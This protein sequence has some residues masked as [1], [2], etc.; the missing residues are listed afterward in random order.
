M[1]E[2]ERAP[3]PRRRR[4]PRGRVA[5]PSQHVR[6]PGGTG[7][8]LAAILERP[9]GGTP[10]SCA[11]LAHAFASSKDLR[12]YSRIADALV[13]KGYALLRFD[14]TGLGQSG[15]E[16]RDTTFSTEIDDLVAAADFMRKE[17]EAPS[18]LIGHSLGGACVLAGAQRIPES[19]AVAT[20]A[21]P[22][23][24][25]HLRRKLLRMAP[26]LETEEYANAD[27]IGKTITLS[28]AMLDDLAGH[29]LAAHV[30]DLDRA[31]LV[32]HS[33]LDTFV[34]IEHAARIFQAAKHPKSFVSLDDADHLLLESER[35]ARFVAGVLAAWAE[36][37]V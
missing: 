15:G 12:G 36:R 25:D 24:L 9:E 20:L 14:F 7:H 3:S 32:F 19:R 29:D 37:Y 10:T 31:L 34:D 22:S 13:E 2:V 17:Y 18:L 4:G 8:E 21:A 27:V 6:F 16:F 1:E 28:R 33:P 11:L 30:G 26:A 35:D 23:N 5:I